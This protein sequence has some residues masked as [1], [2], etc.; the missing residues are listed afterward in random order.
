MGEYGLSEVWVMGVSTL[1]E[2][3]LV[4]KCKVPHLTLGH[5][6]VEKEAAPFKI[7]SK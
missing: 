2:L 4:D 6:M 3:C 1:I 7:N 5:G